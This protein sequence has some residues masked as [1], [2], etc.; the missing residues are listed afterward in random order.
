MCEC[1]YWCG[2]VDGCELLVWF[3]CGCDVDFL[4]CI[5]CVC[6]ENLGIGCFDC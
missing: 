5:V 4:F 6:D 2:W 3:E 1:E